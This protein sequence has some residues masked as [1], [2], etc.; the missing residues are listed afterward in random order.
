MI[1]TGL[2]NL[3]HLILN[4]TLTFSIPK[5]PEQAL[6]YINTIFDYMVG[7]TGIVANYTPL[8]YLLVLFGVILAVDV[9]LLLYHFI[10]WILR[11]IPMLGIE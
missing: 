3:I 5:L 2:L 9:A 6:E 7:A 1:I 8:S 10:M 11:K 4:A